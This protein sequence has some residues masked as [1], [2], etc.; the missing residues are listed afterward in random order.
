VTNLAI[1][2]NVIAVEI[3]Q[4]G[5]ASTDITWGGQ[6]SLFV[7]STIPVPVPPL[8]ACT[9]I[10][11]TLPALRFQRVNGTNTLLSWTN[12][13]TNT[14]G[15]NAVFTLQQTLSLSNPASASRWSNVT[16]VGPYTAIG[17]NTRFFRLKL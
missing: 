8:S 3:H 14:C 7:P 4:N 6:F 2:D 13:A 9:N 12:P 5:T 1:G 10:A 16:A 17:T 15:S 11:L